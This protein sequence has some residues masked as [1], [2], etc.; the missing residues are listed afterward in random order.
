LVRIAAEVI[1]EDTI[2]I[3]DA[4]E[5]IENGHLGGLPE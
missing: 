3:T 5:A 1:Y 4:Y 2:E